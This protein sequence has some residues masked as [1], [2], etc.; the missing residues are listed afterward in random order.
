[1]AEPGEVVA[2]GKGIG[3]TNRRRLCASNRQFMFP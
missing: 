2:D 1:M 3:T